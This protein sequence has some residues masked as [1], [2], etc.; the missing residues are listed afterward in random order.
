MDCCVDGQIVDMTNGSEMGTL[1]KVWPGALVNIC[2][3]AD[4]F[5]V[6]CKFKADN[7]LPQAVL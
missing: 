1:S 4:N 5:R 2:T 3:K 7:G 6:S